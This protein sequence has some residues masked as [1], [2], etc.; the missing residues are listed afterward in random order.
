MPYVR[1]ASRSDAGRVRSLNEDSI[2][3]RPDLGLWVVADG[4]GGH[5]RGDVASAMV[6]DALGRIAP[7]GS[8]LDLLYAVR[9]SLRATNARLVEEARDQGEGAVGTTVVA[10]M[11]YQDHYACVW[12]GDSRCYLWRDQSLTRL[13][14]DDSLI[15]D[16]IDAGTLS[17]SDSERH[18]LA[19]VVTQAIGADSQLELSTVHGPLAP[20]DRLLLCSD[21]LTRMV[22]D[23][24]LAAILRSG[25]AVASLPDALVERAL[26]AGGRDNVSVIVIDYGGQDGPDQQGYWLD[27]T[28]VRDP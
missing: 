3:E 6:C 28:M 21:G 22:Q 18:P 2:L 23:A 24:D 15:Q 26:A 25:A 19:N 12:A 11:I 16:M 8:G 14:R 27:T 17:E 4:M 1:S 13:T 7:P 5:S 10:L 9:T 20:G